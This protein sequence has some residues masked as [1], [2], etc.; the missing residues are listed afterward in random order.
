MYS[1]LDTGKPELLASNTPPSCGPTKLREAAAIIYQ[2]E[3]PS[4]NRCRLYP[5]FVV[6]IPEAELTGKADASSIEAQAAFK[7]L[8]A[9]SN[10]AP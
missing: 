4:P 5:C 7:L 9:Q 3:R 1:I 6:V 10:D 2:Y 8:R